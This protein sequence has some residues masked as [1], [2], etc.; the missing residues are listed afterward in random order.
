MTSK[1]DIY[2]KQLSDI[3]GFLKKKGLKESYAKRIVDAVASDPKYEKDL[4]KMMYYRNQA[5]AAVKAKKQE[6]AK[7][8][9][10]RYVSNIRFLGS[11]GIID[12]ARDDAKKVAAKKGESS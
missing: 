2:R 3:K 1:E 10:D 7:K 5:K 12:L 8:N 11:R 4:Q 9:M 6:E